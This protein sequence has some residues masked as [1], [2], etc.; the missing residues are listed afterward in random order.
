MNAATRRKSPAKNLAARKIIVDIRRALWHIETMNNA[1][2]TQTDLTVANTIREQ[3]GAGTFLMLGAKDLVGDT[4]SLQF[5]ISG[6]KAISHI[7]IKLDPSDTYT[8]T[9]YKVRKFDWSEVKEVSDVYTENLH[10]V[11]RSATGLETQ[12][13]RIVRS[14]RA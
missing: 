3:I 1:A 7:R 5:K 9:F 8:A 14:A 10:S 6:C 4:D 12:V 11:I 13:P 2:M